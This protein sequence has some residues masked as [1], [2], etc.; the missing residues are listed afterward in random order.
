M[1][2]WKWRPPAIVETLV[3][4][5]LAAALVWPL[6]KVKYL[7]QWHS[8]ESTFIADAR[9]LAA[10]W[11]HP[12]W[13]PL[14]Y[15]GTRFDY[16]YPPALRYGTAVLLKLFPALLPVRAYHLFIATFYALGIGG[17]YLLVRRMSGSRA[18][19]WI[20]AA[21]TALM[22]PSFL[23]L[24][25]FRQDAWHG[26]P[27][28]ISAL[29]RYGEGPHVTTLAVMPFAILF[30]FR[31]LPAWRP[32]ALAAASLLCALIVSI[33]FYGA[34]AMATFAAAV[35]WSVWLT[36]P[37]W[38]V[39]LRAAIVGV[40]TYGL[41]A[42]WLTPS[43]LQVTTENLKYVAEP[44]NL[45]S[46]W[47][48]LALVIAFLRISY[49]FARGR[50]ELAWAVFLWASLVLYGVNVI[51]NYFFDFRVVGVPLR[52]VP[53]L[54]FVIVLIAVEGLR[55]L[56]DRRPDLI[57]RTAIAIVILLS[58]AT[59]RHYVRHA[60]G[61]FASDPEPQQRVEYELTD[62]MRRNQPEAR[63]LAAGT[64]RFWYDAW[65]D[66]PQLGGGSDQGVTNGMVMYPYWHLT[67]GDDRELA[68][69]WLQAMGV[70]AIIADSEKSREIYHDFKHI[71]RFESFPVLY[72]NH[73]GDVIYG[74]PR[75][76]PSLARVVDRTAIAS[77]KPIDRQPSRDQLAAYV[78]LLEHGPDAAAA[79]HWQTTD[80]LEVRA[81]AAQN[82]AIVLQVSYDPAWHA[83]SAG[84]AVPVYKDLL[85][86]MWLDTPPGD[87]ALR[88][89]FELPL[90]NSAGRALTALSLAALA[91]L[92]TRAKERP[93]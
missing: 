76:Y 23:L 72:D 43:Y 12:L 62:W 46:K 38:R 61:I 45:W 73:R 90:E 64:V 15:C 27:V 52:L 68:T 14:W 3:A 13:Q 74:V 79:T 22:S 87:H 19:A 1:S 53:E 66:L 89:V 34:T 47:V 35:C 69:L 55:R 58:F 51:G 2:F 80:E 88:V 71:E 82:Q 59:T 25:Q 65:Y 36:Q 9:F 10:H 37:E 42:F 86:N 57:T 32:R 24:Q 91:C 16:V 31:A 29:I 60:W 28:R 11:P 77:M 17:I 21:A 39:W 67:V 8:I 63:T 7:D 20:S 93:A 41:T 33:N 30:L 6:F 81:R 56:W 54:D 18:A 40:L 85:G 78:R 92:S 84:A 26:A 50:P 44:P 83:Y 49:R 4:A 75:R 5:A 48:A 70:D